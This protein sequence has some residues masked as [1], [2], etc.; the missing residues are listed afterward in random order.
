MD[1]LSWTLL[2]VAGGSLLA[3]GYAALKTRWIFKQAVENPK[4]VRISG[5]VADGAMAFLAREYKVLIPFVLLVA[6]FLAVAN[7]GSLRYQSVAYVLGAVTSALAGFIGM[8]NFAKEVHS[9]VMSPVWQ[10]A[11]RR[12]NKGAL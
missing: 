11:P 5:F 8:L 2:F 10:F 1:A 9:S 6:A 3:L 12:A 7:E 4:L